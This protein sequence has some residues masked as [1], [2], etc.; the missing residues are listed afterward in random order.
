MYRKFKVAVLA[1]AFALSSV[2]FAD[3]EIVFCNSFD[4]QFNPENPGTEFAST[5]ISWFAKFDKPL[6]VPIVVISLY[7]N[8]NENNQQL[9]L[10]EPMQVNPNW[11]AIGFRNSLF[12]SEGTYEVAVNLEDGKNLANGI[13]KLIKASATETV[14]VEPKKEEKV[15][16]SLEDLF[17]RYAPK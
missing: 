5:Q 3:G 1:S 8:Q 9:I 12:P 15:G 16:T 13:V 2:C 10:R 7:Q 14:K 17:N 4:D 6:G 11:N